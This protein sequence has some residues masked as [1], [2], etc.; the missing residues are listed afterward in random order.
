[1]S[2]VKRQTDPD[3]LL[4]QAA[5]DP[6]RLAILRQL[7]ACDEVCACDFTSCCDVS[8]PTVS[9]HLKV[10]RDAGWVAADRRGTW[11]YYQLRPEAVA[12][13]RQL[14]FQIEPSGDAGRVPSTSRRLPVVHLPA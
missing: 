2:A 13:F 10:L 1:M 14:A 9:H 8:Q 5:A 4:L 7:S 11:V 12:R 3:V 6:T